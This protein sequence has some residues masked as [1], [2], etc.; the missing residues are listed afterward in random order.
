MYRH[1]PGAEAGDQRAGEWREQGFP[2]EEDMLDWNENQ[3]RVPLRSSPPLGAA[4][5][6]F[7]IYLTQ[8]RHS[9]PTPA[10]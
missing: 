1:L 9:H 10:R 2:S 8:R 7:F 5:S 4:E 3:Q 6:L